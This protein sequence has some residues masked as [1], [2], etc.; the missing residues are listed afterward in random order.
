M[1]VEGQLRIGTRKSPLAM[2]QA[3]LVA[4]LLRENGVDTEIIGISTQG[5]R[6]QRPFREMQGRGLFV[7]ELQSALLRGD[8]DMAV[9]SAKD[10]SLEAQE[11]TTIGAYPERVD[12]RD[13]LCGVSGVSVAR[14]LSSTSEIIDILGDVKL[15]I[16]T[17]SARRSAGVNTWNE[18]YS[19]VDLRGSVETRL[20]KSAERGDA[21][22]ILA[23]AGLKRLGLEKH[24]SALLGPSVSVPEPGQGALAVEC[25]SDDERTVAALAKIDDVSVRQRVEI[26]RRI[27]LALGGGCERPV[28]VYV[29]EH[30]KVYVFAP[31]TGTDEYEQAEFEL[32][33]SS[34][35][36]DEI[37]LSVTEQFGG[38]KV[39][40]VGAGPGS[41]DLI[42]VGAMNLV[43]SADVLVYD[44]LIPES[45]L[46][47]A[48]PGAEA[49]CAG[50]RA[51]DHTLSQDETNQI[52]VSRALGGQTVV[53]LKGGDPFVFGRGGEEA[54][55]CRENGVRF[56]VVSGVTSAV[57]VPAAAGI[58]VTHRG[59]SDNF[60]VVTASVGADGQSE[61][62]WNWL[63][64][65]S[66]TVVI[67][68]GLRKVRKIASSLISAGAPQTRPVAVISQGTEPTQRTVSGTL[69][70]IA[71]R[72]D[73]AGLQTPAIIVVG[74]TVNLRETLSWLESR[75]LH[76]VR[77]G[78]TR[79]RAQAGEL[80][81]LLSDAGARVVECP[82][83]KINPVNDAELDAIVKAP[84]PELILFTSV[85]GVERWFEGIR[86]ADLDARAMS[87]SRI[88]VVGDA[89][90]KACV[91]N[92]VRPDIIAPKGKRTAA[93][94]A[95][96]CTQ[97]I[98][99]AATALVVRGDRA[100]GELVE[101][102]RSSGVEVEEL[103]VYENVI[104]NASDEL[105]ASVLECDV[106]TFS[107][108]ST[109]TNLTSMISDSQIGQSSATDITSI[110]CV[111]IGPQTTAA[112]TKSGFQVHGEARNPGVAG[113]FSEVIN[114]QRRR[115]NQP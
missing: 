99:S 70:D 100:S 26:E 11:K 86:K 13:C 97:N 10:L 20:R 55:Y 12:A 80:T 69:S 16:G 43:R 49:I 23:A 59:I 84:L 38:G 75:P 92:G 46:Q 18:K 72:V 107:S 111:T 105:V 19:A 71:D 78:V 112:A 60:T 15:D 115:Q 35:D 44:H 17:S 24:I 45:I 6:D 1:G 93:G 82:V 33:E 94:L 79:A 4:S 8:I 54:A 68:M 91:A 88:G 57:S 85:N 14:E 76:D 110:P 65:S 89:S 36:I 103:T 102:L 58:P 34:N 67:L 81:K 77:I 109:V 32:N 7:Q 51:G 47:Y 113:L 40:L 66:G 95:D 104:E 56:E 52:L 63:A 28:G 64:A 5:D 53:R 29:D 41:I 25:R 37:V 87:H 96:E 74:D 48:K 22:C 30:N 98:S 108:A 2:L 101:K 114:W 90:F 27:A 9:H 39:Y 62:D 106:L 31:K 42:T 50:K 3:K 73:D 21:A 61:P 83:I